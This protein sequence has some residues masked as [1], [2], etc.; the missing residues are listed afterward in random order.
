MKANSCTLASSP[1]SRLLV[2]SALLISAEGAGAATL[3]GYWDF[4]NPA[5]IGQATV[6]SNLTVV[7]AAPAYSA[8]VSDGSTSL[9]GVAAT[10]GGTANRLIMPNPVG[11]NGGGSFTNEYSFLFDIFSPAASRSS[12]RALIQTNTGNSNDADYFIRNSDDRIGISSPLGYSTNPIND[13]VWTRLL[14]TF[15]I[16][17]TGSTSFVRAYVNGT[18]F[19]THSFSGG[20]DGTYGLES[21]VLLFADNSNENASLNVGAVAFWNGILTPSEV[22]SLGAVGTAVPEPAAALLGGLGLLTLLRRRRA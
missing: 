16:N 6:G 17:A 20:R 4:S 2:L 14:L 19:H 15:D 1:L 12:W 10:V 8:S 7:G 21:T 11:G 13:S 18:L 22:S 3:A 5:N 9:S